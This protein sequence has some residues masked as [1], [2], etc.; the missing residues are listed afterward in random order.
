M[1][2]LVKVIAGLFLL[3]ACSQALG[4]DARF[5]VSLVVLPERV[6]TGMPLDLPTPPQ[7]QVLP[8]SRDAKR[9]LYAGNPG[10]A[11]HFYEGA[12][13]GLG[14]YLSQQDANGAVWERRDVRV[15]L[16]FYP[17]VG[18]EATGIHVMISP[19]A[20]IGAEG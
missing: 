20:L 13:P 11:R 9:L 12:L 10:E 5:R 15:E 2:P 17:V 3:A 4:Q 16:K 14:F 7:A 18:H 8:A 6:A 1:S 19:R